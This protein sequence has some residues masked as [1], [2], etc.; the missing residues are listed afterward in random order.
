MSKIVQCACVVL[1]VVFLPCASIAQQATASGDLRNTTITG[2]STN[3]QYVA[4]HQLTRDGQAI[5]AGGIAVPP[6][7]K[8]A[9]DGKCVFQYY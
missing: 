9:F 7:G 6:D 3:I 5:G 4:A 2:V 1:S 8:I